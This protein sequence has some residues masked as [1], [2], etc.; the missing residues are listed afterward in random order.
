MILFCCMLWHPFL[1][2][3]VKVRLGPGSGS[4]VQIKSPP[5][6]GMM[7]L[8]YIYVEGERG[9]L[10]RTGANETMESKQ[11]FLFFPLP[12][13]TIPWPWAQMYWVLTWF[14]TSS[15]SL[16]LWTCELITCELGISICRKLPARPGTEVA[17]PQS[18]ALGNSTGLLALVAR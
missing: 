4:Q 9:R 1:V 8:C 16:A 14:A 7:D 12:I 13:D 10:S 11:I 3:A 6:L 17:M 5:R 2:G 15:C 18:T